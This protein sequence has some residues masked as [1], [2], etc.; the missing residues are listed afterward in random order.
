MPVFRRTLRA[1]RWHMIGYGIGLVAW[2]VLV[3]ALYP[4]IGKSYGAL[5]LPEAYRAMFGIASGNLGNFRTFANIEFYQWVPV[6]LAIYV[7]TAATGTLAG[8]EG[9]GSLEVL[10]AQPVSRAR[11]FVSKV[12]AIALGALVIAAVTTVGLLV[13][14]AFIDIG[15]DLTVARLGA[16]VF[17]TLPLVALVASLALLV[18][19]VAPSRGTAAGIVSAIFIAAWLANGLGALSSQTE[20]LK[21]LSGF[22]YADVQT[23]LTSG[24]HP[25]HQAVV[26]AVTAVQT[27]LALVA[28]DRREIE[29]A[30][31]Q[32]DAL[33]PRRG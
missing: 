4:S 17:Y 24:L 6:V 13:S 11:L 19:A 14:L 8:E 16:A 1:L 33:L 23:V 28:F 20:W 7:I 18:A 15:S 12:L 5:E 26:L 30:R 21:Y 3:A 29:V 10:L 27:A 22:Y 31:W 2:A 32:F 25:A 9:R